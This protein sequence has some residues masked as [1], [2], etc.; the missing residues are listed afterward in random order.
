MTFN[1]EHGGFAMSVQIGEIFDDEWVPTSWYARLAWA[2]CD[3]DSR[4]FVPVEA[5]GEPF[6]HSP[7]LVS[8]A[9]EAIK[10]AI[11]D[12]TQRFEPDE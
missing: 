11:H 5:F 8:C 6:G 9:T 4:E 1:I 10:R 7:D 2:E 3:P 12:I